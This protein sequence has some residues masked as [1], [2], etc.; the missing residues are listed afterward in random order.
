[1]SQAHGLDIRVPIGALFTLLGVMIGG[2][3]LATAGDAER[4]ARSLSINVNLWWGVVMLVFGL[5]LLVAARRTRHPAA[6]HPAM[7]TPEG[8]DTEKREEKLGLER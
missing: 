6:A 7:E 8:R 1:M 3:G 5:I 2:Y 4:Y